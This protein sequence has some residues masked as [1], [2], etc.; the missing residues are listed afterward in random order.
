MTHPVENDFRATWGALLSFAL[1][2]GV[3]FQDAEDLVSA[4]IHVSLD[5]YSSEKG[6]FLSFCMTVLNNKIKNHWRDQK[7]HEPFDD[8]VSFDDEQRVIMEE[9]EERAAMSS[10]LQ[11]IRE[12]LTPEEVD[13]MTALGTA[14]EE[15]DSRAVSE[16]ARTLGL[17][18][19]KG[20]DLFRRIQ[21]KARSL[22]PAM[23]VGEELPVAAKARPAASQ[24]VVSSAEVLYQQTIPAA[25]MRATAPPLPTLLNLARA[26]ARN[27][28][29]ARLFSSLTPEQSKKLQII[30][31]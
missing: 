19:E 18:P 13:F 16:A 8:E 22:Y 24:N 1:R 23:Q 12:K 15:L 27:A 20:W 26:E 11:R 10:I 14:L 30:S 7:P 6:K 31:F 29:F 2:K 4:T 9:E 28:G 21:R 3:P 5:R 17:A 25:P